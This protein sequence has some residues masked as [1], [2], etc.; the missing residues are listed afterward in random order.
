MA[1]LKILMLTHYFE[2]HRGGIEL[3]ANALAQALRS[4]GFGL[5]WLA[6]DKRQT[7]DGRRDDWRRVLA[8][9]NICETLLKV[10]YPLLYPSAWRAILAE[11]K[12]ADVVLVHDAIY[13][14]AIV[15]W[16]AARLY[17]KPMVVVQH[18][19]TVPYQNPLLRVL[20]AL[21]NRLI[22]LPIL[23]RAD[24]VVFISELTA[25]FFRGVR[26]RRPPVLI[27]NGVDTQIFHPPT[28]QKE[29]AEARAHLDLPP[30]ASIAL[31][32]GRFVEKKGLAVLERV[33]RAHPNVLFIFA[34]WGSIDPASWRLLNVRVCRSLSGASL[35]SL[36]RASNVLLL[37][38]VGEGFPLVVQEALACGLPMICG[39]DTAQADAAATDFL[40]AVPVHLEDP[41][42]T[43]RL[44][45]Q[46]MLRM[47]HDGT[48]DTDRQARSGFAQERYSWSKTASA[49]V[50]LLRET[51]A[52]HCAVAS[53]NEIGAYQAGARSS[54]NDR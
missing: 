36:Y 15:S 16:L 31:F 51:C 11:A 8:A 42:S 46:E 38:S 44:F 39:T 10:P 52:Q 40:T 19:G 35:A 6:T 45:A 50:R 29:I 1:E 53:L 9:S 41:D 2:R 3:V 34:G 32:V 13:M 43:A 5:R 17:R 48:T 37:P 30:D 49:Y 14:T 4:R 23:R 47:L 25:S 33:A 27:F 12:A 20:M 7:N 26:L 22:T 21:G 24:R 18:I 54:A 28:G